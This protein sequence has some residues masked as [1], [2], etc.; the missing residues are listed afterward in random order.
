M[1][2]MRIKLRQFLALL[3][4]SAPIPSTGGCTAFFEPSYILYPKS[5]LQ[6]VN[7]VHG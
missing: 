6:F 4:K 1:A 5:I 7:L 2:M 3:L